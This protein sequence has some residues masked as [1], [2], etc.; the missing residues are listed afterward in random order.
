MTV[1]YMSFYPQHYIE[2]MAAGLPAPF[3]KVAKT[4]SGL[5]FGKWDFEE[6][7]P[8][9][10]VKIIKRP[11]FNVA[12]NPVVDCVVFGGWEFWRI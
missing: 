10:E 3:V 8:K 7:L 1:T 11:L 12:G 5:L 9:T 6:G 4:A 2:K